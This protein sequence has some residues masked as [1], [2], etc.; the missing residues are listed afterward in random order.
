MIGRTNARCG[1][2][3]IAGGMPIDITIVGGTAQPG[4]P[5]DHTVWINTSVPITSYV[6]SYNEP[7]AYDQG[8]IW[9]EIQSDSDN[10]INVSDDVDLG[11]GIVRQYVN[12]GWKFMAGKVYQNSTWTPIQTWVYYCGVY[13]TTLGGTWTRNNTSGTLLD[14]DG[15]IEK[16]NGSSNYSS[17]K[18]I[19]LTNI[20]SVIFDLEVLRAGTYNFGYISVSAKS[21]SYSNTWTNAPSTART[22]LGS[23]AV[24]QKYT[25]NVSDLTGNYYI[26]IGANSASGTSRVRVFS[27]E[28]R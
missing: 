4:N 13:N 10:I 15:F 14:E 12:G 27:I 16:V 6:I 9:I 24:R 25:L 28:L 1:G 21:G 17:G 20:S 18:A 26:T 8:M 5:E 23:A 11:I 2:S 7:T 3:E 22:K 19:D